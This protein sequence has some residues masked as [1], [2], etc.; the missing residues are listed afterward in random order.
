MAHRTSR[1]QRFRKLWLMLPVATLLALAPGAATSAVAASDH[2]DH[3]GPT[4]TPQQS[5]TTNRLQAISPVNARVV[6]A[7]GVGGTFVRTLD[8]GRTWQAGIVAGAETL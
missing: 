7:S 2:R 6:W 4:L 1:V 8:G 5:G 3:A